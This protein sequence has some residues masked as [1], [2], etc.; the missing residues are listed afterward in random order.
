[1]T[2]RR[3]DIDKMRSILKQGGMDAQQID[4]VV[5]PLRRRQGTMPI[6]EKLRAVVTKIVQEKG[7]MVLF[8]LNRPSEGVPAWD[9]VVSAQWL[10]KDTRAGLIYVGDCISSALTS[11]EMTSLGQIVWLP[12]DDPYVRSITANTGVPP[13]GSSYIA[14][15]ILGGVPV[16]EMW[17]LCSQRPATLKSV[18]SKEKDH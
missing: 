12:P 9:V 17:L 3:L 15:S 18:N 2:E 4:E 6:A 5:P 13:G 10:R 11:D 16:E 14:K 7:S 8:A 1:M